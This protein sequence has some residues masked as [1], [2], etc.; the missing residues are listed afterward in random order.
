MIEREKPNMHLIKDNNYLNKC[1]SLLLITVF[2]I[3]VLILIAFINKVDKLSAIF[4]KHEAFERAIGLPTLSVVARFESGGRSVQA[5]R[6][7]DKDSDSSI[8]NSSSVVLKQN[9]GSYYTNLRAVV[10]WLKGKIIGC[11]PFESIAKKCSYRL[12]WCFDG[13]HSWSIHLRHFGQRLGVD[14]W[15]TNWVSILLRFKNEF[16]SGN[17]GIVNCVDCIDTCSCFCSLIQLGGDKCVL[18]AKIS[19][20]MLGPIKTIERTLLSLVRF[21]KDINELIMMVDSIDAND[22][23][24]DT[25]F[26]ISN[27]GTGSDETDDNSTAISAYKFGVNNL[28]VQKQSNC[29]ARHKQYFLSDSFAASGFEA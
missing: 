16:S 24:I 10:L 6:F 23:L 19:R 17:I 7:G 21:L 14:N 18:V 2:V 15:Y 5:L 4:E 3:V 29:F 1:L 20:K 22:K 25:P 28:T 27:N 13:V 12:D 9:F 11:S 8:G 26:R